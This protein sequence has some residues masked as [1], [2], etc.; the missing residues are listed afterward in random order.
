MTPKKNPLNNN[1]KFGSQHDLK[2]FVFQDFRRIIEKE[3]FCDLAIHYSEKANHNI[4]LILELKLNFE[5]QQGLPI[6]AVRNTDDLN[7]HLNT[8]SDY[9][10]LNRLQQLAEQSSHKIDIEELT[11]VFTDCSL[12]IH[13]IFNQSIIS[14]VR[15]IIQKIDDNQLNLT[16]GFTEVPYEI[17]IPVFEEKPLYGE[18]NLLKFKTE[19]TKICDYYKFWAVY[20]EHKIDASFYDVAN[21]EIFD[22]DLTM[23]NY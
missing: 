23:I 17:H 6:I 4:D 7:F 16:K 19:E 18:I 8:N 14:Q 2:S 15:N 21:N 22:G 9:L 20:F 10:F 1:L 12:I 11:I 3:F 5:L 13:R